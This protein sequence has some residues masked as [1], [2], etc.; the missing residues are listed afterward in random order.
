[1]KEKGGEIMLIEPVK[2]YEDSFHVTY[3]FRI[4]E[5]FQTRE[6]AI[7]SRGEFKPSLDAINIVR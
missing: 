3:T 5:I 2:L 7:E 6:E 1:M 4:F